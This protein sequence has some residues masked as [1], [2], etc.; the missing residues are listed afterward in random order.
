MQQHQLTLPVYLRD[1]ATMDNFLPVAGS[2][3]A[4]AAL[5]EL[6]GGG[7]ERI[8]LLHGPSGSGKSHLLQAC[9][10]SAGEH[11]LYLPLGELASY[12]ADQVLEGIDAMQLLCLDDLQAILGKADWET[13]LFN[14]YNRARES[15]QSLILAANAPP[16][17]LPVALADLQS[18]LSWAVVFQLPAIDD[19]RR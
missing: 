4:R 10:H 17:Q 14:L 11:A 15:G 19:D 6:L 7:G 18:R 1:D 3:A 2:E 16:R 13:A 5:G 9:C 12:P 8:I